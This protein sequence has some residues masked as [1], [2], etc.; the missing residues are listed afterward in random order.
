MF[1]L[2]VNLYIM[3]DGQNYKETMLKVNKMDSLL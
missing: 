3:R 2:K 1:K